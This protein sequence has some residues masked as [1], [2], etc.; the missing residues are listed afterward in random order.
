[1]STLSI[2][3]PTDTFG[4]RDEH[5]GPWYLSEDW[6]FGTPEEQSSPMTA[7]LF[8]GSLRKERFDQLFLNPQENSR[9]P[10]VGSS[11]EILMSVSQS[12][13]CGLDVAWLHS[14]KKIYML[15]TCSWSDAVELW[16]FLKLETCRKRLGHRKRHT[17]KNE[18]TSCRILTFP[19]TTS[20][21]TKVMPWACS[22][23]VLWTT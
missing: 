15:Q 17:Q 18:Q 13:F 9:G 23:H 21:H 10:S 6:Y 11:G 7:Q 2:P 22:G 12:L 19:T 1:M 20:C 4:C 8:A 5:G 14:L 16:S 3:F